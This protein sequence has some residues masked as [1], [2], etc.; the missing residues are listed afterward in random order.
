M[1]EASVGDPVRFPDI[2]PRKSSL[3]GSQ[4]NRQSTIQSIVRGA[5]FKTH[6][7][8]SVRF[9]PEDNNETRIKV[10]ASELFSRSPHGH[11]LAKV[12]SGEEGHTSFMAFLNSH[13]ALDVEFLLAAETVKESVDKADFADRAQ[14]F[15][16][17]FLKDRSDVNVTPA[18]RQ[19]ALDVLMALHLHGPA[20]PFCGPIEPSI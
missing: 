1:S 9:T 15:G 12:L 7:K 8:G 5:Q 17:K 4:K 3:I 10:V 18:R 2:V 14:Q 19:S 20:G 16:F 13:H 11:F 6:R